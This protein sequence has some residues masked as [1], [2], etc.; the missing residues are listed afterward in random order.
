M[1]KFIFATL[2]MALGVMLFTASPG[3]CVHK[4]SVEKVEI[5]SHSYIDYTAPDFEVVNTFGFSH[6][7]KPV[8]HIFIE[9]KNCENLTSKNP[10]KPDK[11]PTEM[12]KYFTHNLNEHNLK[13]GFIPSLCFSYLKPDP[14]PNHYC[15]VGKRYSSVS[16]RC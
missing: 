8:N 6:D 1:K 4:K 12:F 3:Y 10:I 13:L 11:I 16:F 15:K 9:V 14:A 7:I 5:T 2:F